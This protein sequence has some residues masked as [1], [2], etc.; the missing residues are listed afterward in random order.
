[1]KKFPLPTFFVTLFIMIALAACNREDAVTTPAPPTYEV[2]GAWHGAATLEDG[3]A[4]ES[5]DVS[6]TMQVTGTDVTL[7]YRQGASDP[8]LY[9]GT[10]TGVTLSVDAGASQL[11]GTF[12]SAD[13]FSGAIVNASD[14]TKKAD[15]ALSRGQA[16]PTPE[17]APGPAPGPT[18]G[19]EPEPSF[20]LALSHD[21]VEVTL[22]GTSSLTVALEN[23]QNLSGEPTIALTGADGAPVD[24]T[25]GVKWAVQPIDDGS[26]GVSYN[27]AFSAPSSTATPGSYAYGVRVTFDGAGDGTGGGAGAVSQE[28]SLT[29]NVT[30]PPEAAPLTWTKAANAPLA[31]FEAQ[32]AAV[33]GALYVFGGF[34]NHDVK[35]TTESFA[36][37]A[38]ANTWKRRSDMPVP[39]THAGTA[40]DGERVYLAGGFTGDHPGPSSDVVLV[41]NTREDTWARGPSLPEK[42]GGGALVK[43]DRTLHFFGGTVRVGG[44]YLEDKGD[45]W[46][47]DLDNPVAWKIAAPLP[48][49]R[50]HI[51]GAA[52]GGKI[53][54][55]GGQHLGDE[56][57]GNQRSVHVF[58]PATGTWQAVAPL[59]L[60]LSHTSASTLAWGGHLIV[61]GGVTQK[62]E[63]VKTVL[64][65]D[66]GANTWRKLTPLPAPRQS[67]VAGFV[68]GHLVVTTGSAPDAK[69]ESNSWVGK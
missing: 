31:L 15:L 16:Q 61:V 7:E 35:A 24:S 67:P 41:Y 20:D 45:H 37:D 50:N 21:T 25:D 23:E 47:L 18:P 26:G 40:V 65:Y 62:S 66:P 17:P 10:L 27:L 6:W 43:L 39:L 69:P 9:T 49:P 60:P 59:P 57:G 29:V 1:M 3:G 8:T 56:E 22:D 44:R 2:S 34:Y 4:P 28:A 30:P 52:L 46:T 11:G 42:R 53:Y 12:G 14:N 68:N 64:E 36:Y 58:D 51:A 48:N 55:V 32:G 63:E 13:S 54:A 19:P 38:S 5:V 33:D